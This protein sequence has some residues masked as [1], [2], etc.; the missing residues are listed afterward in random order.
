MINSCS[1]CTIADEEYRIV[2][3]ASK[4]YSI[5]PNTALTSGHVMV[6]PYRH[7]TFEE[8]DDEEL[9]QIRDMT[10][11]LKTRLTTLYPSTPPLFTSMLDTTHASIPDHVHFHLIPSPVNV[12]PLL[13]S[14]FKRSP[15]RI[16]LPR[17]ELEELARQLR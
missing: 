17:L 8:M 4:V 13:A 11:Q 1:L 14:Y 12:T 7:T 3:C 16:I 6:L 10:C 15:E 9:S 2:K 5:I